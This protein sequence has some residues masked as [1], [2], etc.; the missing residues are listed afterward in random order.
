MAFL[1]EQMPGKSRSS[2]KSQL[3]KGLI[4]V[5][6][7]AVKQFNHALSIGQKVILNTVLEKKP[8]TEGSVQIVFE[9]KDVLVVHKKAGFLSVGTEKE[10]AKTVFSFL[11]EHVKK[12]KESNRVYV[13][14]R[15]DREISGLMLFA[16]N[17]KAEAMLQSSWQVNLN[18]QGYTAILEGE[19]QKTK[20][21]IKSFLKE[22]RAMVMYS[23]QS[24]NDALEARTS[25]EVIKK[26]TDYSLV[27]IEIET[28]RKNQ[29]RVHM[30]DLGHPIVGDEKYEALTDPIKRVALHAGRLIFQH[31]STGE[32]MKF[33]KDMPVKFQRLIKHG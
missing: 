9:D 16:K 5:D 28:A 30:K 18:K 2:I 21:R 29:I 6:G 27:R 25:F 12:E 31:P 13:I 19:L 10:K 32:M 22:N 8:K 7:K 33:E 20:G 4:T 23:T 24:P 14:H 26:N 11:N 15:L 1:L 17:K 3:S